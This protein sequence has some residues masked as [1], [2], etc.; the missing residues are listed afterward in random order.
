MLRKTIIKKAVFLKDNEKLLY[1]KYIN[2]AMCRNKETASQIA[3]NMFIKTGIVHNVLQV[4]S[5]WKHCVIYK[6]K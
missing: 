6:I 4:N 3:A 2:E 1:S 5:Y